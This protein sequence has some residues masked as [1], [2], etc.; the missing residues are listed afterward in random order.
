M[1]ISVSHNCLKNF[2]KFDNKV[3][4]YMFYGDIVTLAV[5]KSNA[6]RGNAGIGR[7]A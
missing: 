2:E 1:K 5:E 4:T 7:Q 6:V 3:L